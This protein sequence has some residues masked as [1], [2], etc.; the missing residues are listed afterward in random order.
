MT[1]DLQKKIHLCNIINIFFFIVLS[2]MLN[3]MDNKKCKIST[4]Y[5]YTKM[6]HTEFSL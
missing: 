4:K 5:L 3:E 2:F 1:H 6:L